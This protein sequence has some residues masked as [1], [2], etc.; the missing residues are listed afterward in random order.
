MT[1]ENPGVIMNLNI[2]PFRI[3][4]IDR[5]LEISALAWA[6]IFESFRHILGDSLFAI[7][8][9][10]HRESQLR[11]IAA[12]CKGKDEWNTWIAEL[13]SMVVGFVTF[14]L[15]HTTKIGILGYNAVHP[16]H[17]NMGIAAKMYELAL[18]KL[19]DGG[20]IAA[21]VGTGGDPS[22]APAR[23]AYEKVGFTGLPLVNYYKKL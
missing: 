23:R 17:Q 2:R 22:H 14:K 1:A 16:E 19:K 15:D 6:P 12:V 18:G 21:N 13:D 5:V 4:D 8:N 10:D 3:T 9:P 7:V 11:G 20:M